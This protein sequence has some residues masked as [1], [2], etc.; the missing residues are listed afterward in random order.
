MTKTMTSR[1]QVLGALT[2][3]PVD[4]VPGCN[5]ANVA[6]VELMDLE[7]APFLMAIREPE[8]NARRERTE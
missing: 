6:T 5:P 1:E 8:R 7:E 4:R 2:G 3:E